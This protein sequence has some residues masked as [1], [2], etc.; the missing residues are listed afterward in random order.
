MDLRPAPDAEAFR[1]HVRA[2]LT[3]HLPDDWPGIGALP[4]DDAAEFVARWRRTLYE[5]GLLGLAWPTDYG[6]GGMSKLEQIVLVEE[7]ARAMVPLGPA[8]DTV[9]VKMVGNTLLKWGTEEQKQRLPAR[10]SSPATTPGARASRSRTRVPTS[11]A[12][13]HGPRSTVTS[14]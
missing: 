3:E 6:G 5:H 10:A 2:F 12:W 13:A 9:T 8:S 7:C 14:G 11:P 1:A 4:A